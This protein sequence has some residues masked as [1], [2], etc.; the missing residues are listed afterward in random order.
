MPPRAWPRWSPAAC[1]TVCEPRGLLTSSTRNHSCLGGVALLTFS[2][3]I[4][5]PAVGGS[6]AQYHHLFETRR[7]RC[8]RYQGR[9][10]GRDF[11]WYT[12]LGTPTQ[13]PSTPLTYSSNA[14]HPTD[15]SRKDFDGGVS[16][17]RQVAEVRLVRSLDVVAAQ[18]HIRKI[19]GKPS[20]RR[21]QRS[22][23]SCSRRT[24]TRRSHCTKRR[25]D[26]RGT[27]RLRLQRGEELRCAEARHRRPR[28][29]IDIVADAVVS[30]GVQ[31]C[32]SALHASANDNH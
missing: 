32:V 9:Y 6:F 25:L 20:S 22:T 5:A 1:S 30:D 13:Q 27:P 17:N 23:A 14:Q 21:A 15:A 16:M 18:V 8:L 12:L 4:C 31:S 2:R 7:P 28:Q 29:S 19:E 26:L 3:A 11:C 24:R 10:G